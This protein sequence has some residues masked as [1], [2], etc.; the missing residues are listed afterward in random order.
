MLQQGILPYIS[1]KKLV[2][3]RALQAAK[4]PK[5]S[6]YRLIAHW[7]TTM[8]RAG[9]VRYSLSRNVTYHSLDPISLMSQ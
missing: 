1:L 8:L 3:T 6:Y 4:M 5:V 9:V 2:D 7:L